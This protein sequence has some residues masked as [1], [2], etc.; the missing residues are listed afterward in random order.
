MDV[1]VKPLANIDVA[2]ALTLVCSFLKQ[3]KNPLK[4]E[5]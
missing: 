3:K 4:L 5:P 2:G 1:L